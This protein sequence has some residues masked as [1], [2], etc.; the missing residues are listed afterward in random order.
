[1]K[2]IKTISQAIEFIKEFG[3]ITQ[4]V[5]GIRRTVLGYHNR[6]FYLSTFVHDF[7]LKIDIFI[8][9]EYV[10]QPTAEFSLTGR[11]I[12]DRVFI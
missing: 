9:S 1:M 8:C 10:S 11:Y 7:E 3:C 2:N 5:E 6:K 4:N 12:D